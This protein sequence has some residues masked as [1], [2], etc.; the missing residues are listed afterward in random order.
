MSGVIAT[1][2]E[3]RFLVQL[4]AYLSFLYLST[5]AAV[6]SASAATVERITGV[7]YE[8]WHSACD[9]NAS[10]AVDCD[11]AGWCVVC[12]LWKHRL[13]S[14]PIA[15]FLSCH[16]FN[17]K[18]DSL[19]STLAKSAPVPAFGTT[20]GSSTGLQLNPSFPTT[21]KQGKEKILCF[22]SMEIIWMW[23]FVI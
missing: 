1:Y 14:M 6:G 2:T 17:L 8:G 9:L 7:W 22:L 4:Q 11:S 12:L 19:A 10:S 16:Q 13:G 21:L 3:M 15:N 5:T 18:F 23:Y 20:A